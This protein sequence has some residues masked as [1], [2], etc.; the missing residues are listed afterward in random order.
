M[1]LSFLKVR[2]VVNNEEIYPLENDKP[3]LIQIKEN[4]PK[5]VITDGFHFTK[6]IQLTYRAPSYYHFRVVCTIDDL[7]LFGGSFLLIIFYLFGFFTVFFILKLL[8][9]LPVICFLAVYY[10]NRK[11]F[12]RIVQDH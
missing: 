11:S 7:Q 2:V 10:L 4:N 8:S 9:F 5:I 6:P 12:M 3:V 1:L